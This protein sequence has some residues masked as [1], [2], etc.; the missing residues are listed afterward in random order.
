[1]KKVALTLAIL[2]IPSAVLA[3][4]KT[5]KEQVYLDTFDKA[6]NTF[7]G[8]ISRFACKLCNDTRYGALIAFNKAS[9]ILVFDESAKLRRR[10]SAKAGGCRPRSSTRPPRRRILCPVD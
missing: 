4:S 5:Y 9:V 6:S 7:S 2:L 3:Q 8:Q 1:M 10:E